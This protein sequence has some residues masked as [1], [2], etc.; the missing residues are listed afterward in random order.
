MCPDPL[1]QRGLSLR[2]EPEH[3]RISS[4]HRQ[5]A[6]LHGA[7]T[8]ALAAGSAA[9]ARSALRH[10]RDA[11]DAHKNLEDGFYFPALRGLRPA[12]APRLAAFSEDHERFGQVLAAIDG[13]LAGPEPAAAAVA[14][15]ALAADI[16]DHERREEELAREVAPA[17]VHPTG[18]IAPASARR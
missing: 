1:D 8:A 15:H 18:P 13:L 2:L 12:L 3:R 10:F 5:L 4:Q 11:W 6:V 16:A 7:V 9:E 14:L 17:E